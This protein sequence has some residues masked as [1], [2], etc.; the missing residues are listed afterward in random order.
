[1][2]EQIDRLNYKHQITMITFVLFLILGALCPLSGDDWKSYI[3]GK[4]GIVEC[5]KNINILDGRIITGFL[6]NFF[7]YNK[8]IF[9]IVFAALIS[10]F[11][12]TCNDLIGAC[13]NKY[14]YTFP[15][16][17]VLL[18][19][20]FAFS[21][22]YM[23]VTSTICYT[24]PAILFFIYFY[25]LIKDDV[26]NDYIKKL[27]IVIFISLSNIHISI[28]L[29]IANLVYFC[30][31]KNKKIEIKYIILIA[32]NL[33]LTVVSLLTLK[34]NFFYDN[35]DILSSSSYL[36]E[37]TFSN[38]ILLIILGAV[39]I[40]Y[41][42][43]EKLKD[44]PYRLISIIL[45]DAILFITLINNVLKYAPVGQNNSLFFKEGWY[46]IFY[47]IL[48]IALLI[49]SANY[50]IKNKRIKNVVFISFISCLVMCFFIFFSPLFNIG[51]TIFIIFFIILV[52][53]VLFE[54]ADVKIYSNVVRV[55][56]YVLVLYYLSIFGIIKYI[57]TT[58]NDS[59]NNQINSH[60]EQITIKESPI[61]LVWKYNPND[62][63][64]DFK[65]YYKIDETKIII[66]KK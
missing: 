3:I 25:L 56:F 58:R 34:T 52:F 62:N 42:L 60:S 35:Y 12:K 26:K 38:N 59:I 63:L 40:N 45:F 54:E 9:D 14:Y 29:L 46:Y 36:I 49:I 24:F 41:Y 61:N 30:I 53:S 32:I 50:Y 43:N 19:S 57:D 16:L 27:L 13:K 2:K 23:T 65:L 48:Y 66:I 44:R 31:I 21:Y 55:T 17:G 51:N 47:F 10:Y 4:E 15:L 28:A 1:M 5:F 37:N 6:V 33:I 7:T 22:S 18:V 11:V 20:V 64:N 8:I 39:P